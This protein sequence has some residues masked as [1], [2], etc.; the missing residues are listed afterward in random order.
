[1][2]SPTTAIKLIR[3]ALGVTNAV[4]VDQELTADEITGALEVL[5]DILEQWSTD[6]LTLW[7]TTNNTFMTVAGQKVY[8]IGPT[9][10]W[11]ASRPERIVLDAYTS[12]PIGS[13]TPQSFPCTMISQQEY[14][15]IAVK[16][17]QNQFALRYLYVNEFPNGLLTL[18]PVPNVAAPFTLSFDRILTQ[19][20]NAGASISYPQ[21]YAK[22]LKMTLAVELAPYFGKQASPDV[23]Q[24]AQQAYADIKR[25]NKTQKVLQFDRATQNRRGWPRGGY[26]GGW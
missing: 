10:D 14:N 4:G 17:Q 21:G 8:G 9:G 6:S 24:I 16:D 2:P 11:V 13:A 22:A 26:I 23:K 3:S 18:W 25:A 1:M 20:T 15:D 19:I 7:S 12:L 5:N